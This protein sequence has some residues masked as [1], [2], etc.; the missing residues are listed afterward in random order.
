M[1]KSVDVDVWVRGTNDAR[2]EALSGVPADASGW[3]EADVRVL[4]TEMLLALDRTKNPGGEP[5]PVVLRGFSWIVSLAPAG[6][7]VH[8]EMKSGTVSAGPFDI[9]ESALTAM[10]TRVMAPSDAET[11]TVH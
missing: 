4:L 6:V 8:L 2:S 10:I 3:N 1:T 5:P 9:D 11:P 7:L